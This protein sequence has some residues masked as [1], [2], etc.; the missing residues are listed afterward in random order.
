M[1]VA[2]LAEIYKIMKQYMY[3]CAFNLKKSKDE[4]KVL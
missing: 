3:F 1:I 4:L 2:A